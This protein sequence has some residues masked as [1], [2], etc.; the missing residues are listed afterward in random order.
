MWEVER[1]VLPSSRQSGPLTQSRLHGS[2]DLLSMNLV[3]PPFVDRRRILAPPIPPNLRDG[4]Q[5]LNPVL[6]YVILPRT[7]PQL[8]HMWTCPEQTRVRVGVG[9]VFYRAWKIAPIH[10]YTYT[11]GPG[12]SSGTS[13][14]LLYRFPA[15]GGFCG[16]HTWHSACKSSFNFDM[17]NSDVNKHRIFRG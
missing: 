2:I 1:F 16:A 11:R 9:Q 3:N 4:Q 15:P 6:R 5:S 10:A 8:V 17:P 14:K 7:E 12:W 13:S